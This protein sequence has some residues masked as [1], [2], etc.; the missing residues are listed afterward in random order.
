M[1][2]KFICFFITALAATNLSFAASFDCGMASTKVETMICANI[3]ISNLD[4]DLSE[5]YK[6]AI[7]LDGNI[8]GSQRAWIK[9]RNQCSDESCVIASYRERIN[10]LKEIILSINQ[11]NISAKYSSFEISTE[12]V[13]AAPEIAANPPNHIEIKAPNPVSSNIQTLPTTSQNPEKSA[14]YAF[15]LKNQIY[16]L[17]VGAIILFTLYKGWNSKCPECEA[18]FRR[19]ETDRDLIDQSRGHKTVNRTDHHKAKNGSTIKTVQRQEQIN[20]II[21]KYLVSYKCEKCNYAWQVVMSEES[22]S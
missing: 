5:S 21:R 6:K 15:Y 12:P 10:E 11:E 18:W 19:E 4:S 2:I 20:I 3:E 9:E 8:K 16:I 13:S 1:H 14:L 17:I 22:E 7:E